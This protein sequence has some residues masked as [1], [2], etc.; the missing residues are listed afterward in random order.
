MNEIEKMIRELV[1][2]M[3]GS[4]DAALNLAMVT[5]DEDFAALSVII[6][7]LMVAIQ[8]GEVIEIAEL[9]AKFAESKTSK[10]A[11]SDLTREAIQNRINL[12]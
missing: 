2:Q 10:T 7:M 1:D 5:G 12:N 11:G 3:S 8:R 6:P 4:A 9:L